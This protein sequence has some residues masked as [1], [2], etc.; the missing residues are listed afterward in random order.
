LVIDGKRIQK[1]L[2]QM[3]H[4][5]AI[6]QGSGRRIFW[7]MALRNASPMTDAVSGCARSIERISS[8]YSFRHVAG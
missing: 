7:R 2:Q 8:P 1:L 5:A 6:I 4:K 3:R